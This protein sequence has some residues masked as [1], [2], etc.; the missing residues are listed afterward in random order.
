MMN[1]S[2][3]VLLALK[4]CTAFVLLKKIV[5]GEQRLGIGVLRDRSVECE[6]LIRR[7]LI[8]IWNK[9]IPKQKY[10]NGY[11]AEKNESTCR[12]DNML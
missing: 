5:I 7:E 11:P 1:W 8:P 10:I 12:S 6:K 4:E 3:E 9:Y 2:L